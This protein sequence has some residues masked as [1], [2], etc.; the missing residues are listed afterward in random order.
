LRLVAGQRQHVERGSFATGGSPDV[1]P[2]AR[3]SA[4][5]RSSL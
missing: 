1:A 2:A 3:R 5:R 4:R